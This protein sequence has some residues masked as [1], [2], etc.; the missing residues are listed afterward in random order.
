MSKKINT[1]LNY[2]FLLIMSIVEKTFD[3]MGR[4][5]KKS[6]DTIKRILEP[7]EKS[8]LKSIKIANKQFENALELTVIFDETLLNK[9]YSKKIEG[10]AIEHDSATGNYYTAQRIL[11]V[12]ITDGTSSFVIDFEPCYNKKLYPALHKNRLELVK[13]MVKKVKNIFPEKKLYFVMDGAF[14]VKEILAWLKENNILVDMRIRKN[15]KIIFCDQKFKLADLFATIG[16]NTT[17]CAKWNEIEL[18]FTKNIYQK[19]NGSAVDVYQAST[20][21][22]KA[23]EHINRYKLR[24]NIEKFFRTAKQHLGL[25]KCQSQSLETQMNHIG[26]VFLAYNYLHV[27]MLKKSLKNP[28]AA[29]KDLRNK[30]QKTKIR[31]LTDWITFSESSFIH[32]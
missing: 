31:I 4:L 18:Y 6:G 9:Q 25:Q 19:K 3:G 5:I 21:F 2:P 11:A 17:I 10:T 23:E 12:Q 13:F 7:K 20:Y 15:A 32:F 30:N 27:Y 24:W 29:I 14:A 22:S 1:I 26:A 8:L 16:I 28:E